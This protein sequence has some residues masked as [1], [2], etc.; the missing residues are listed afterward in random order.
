MIKETYIDEVIQLLRVEWDSSDWVWGLK[1]LIR[2][3]QMD[4]P[5][6]MRWDDETL[7]W[8]CAWLCGFHS[9]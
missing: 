2:A 6:R 9:K 7:R 8:L 3:D 4:L 1:E 5:Y